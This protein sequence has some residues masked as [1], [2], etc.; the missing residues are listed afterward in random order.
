MNMPEC[1][2]IRKHLW[3]YLSLSQVKFKG[4]NLFVCLIL[5]LPVAYMSI[6][7]RRFL[8]VKLTG[9]LC[10]AVYQSPVEVTLSVILPTSF[11]FQYLREVKRFW[12]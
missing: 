10:V 7:L 3:F 12:E 5:L 1:E 9:I 11:G 4:G 6:L 2:K 8:Y